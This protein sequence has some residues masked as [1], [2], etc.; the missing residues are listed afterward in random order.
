[1]CNFTGKSGSIA[2]YLNIEQGIPDFS[3]KYELTLIN[4]LL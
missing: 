4:S 1:M 2:I 3:E